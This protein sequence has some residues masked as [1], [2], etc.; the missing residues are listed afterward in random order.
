MIRKIADL[1]ADLHAS[2]WFIPMLMFSGSI[3]LAILLIQLDL[4]VDTEKLIEYSPIFAISSGGSRAMLAA[5]AGS[6]LTVVALAFTLTLNAMT[7][8]SGQFTPRILRNFMRDR[9]NQFILGYFVGVFAYS[10]LTLLAI[11]S[12]DDVQFVPILATFAGLFFTLGGVIVLIFFIHHIAASLQITTI[13]DKIVDD[14]KKSI[15]KLFPEDLADPAETDEQ[16]QAW[17]ADEDQQWLTVPTLSVGYIQSVDTNGLIKFA[18]E[19]N[20]IL[21]MECG[22]G[23]FVPR[24]A[25]LISLTNDRNTS[26]LDFKIG[27]EVVET[28]NGLFGIDRNRM[29]EQDVRFGIRQIVDIALKALSPGVNDTSTGVNCI[30]YLGDIIGELARKQFPLKVRS[31]DSEPRVIVAA[32]TFEDYVKTAFDQIRISGKGNVAIFEQLTQAIAYSASCTADQSRRQILKK[33]IDLIADFANQ[34]LDTKYEKEKF[35]I[36]LSKARS[37]FKQ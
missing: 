10:L 15:T 25:A 34:T 16:M 27:D 13:I 8:A 24:G 23:R 26:S 22:I 30:Q 36:K 33:Q 12:G 17:Q 9:A 18:E 21:R 14:T 28:L 20:L 19:N 31:N 7:H 37:A 1:W 32:P 5:V 35:R 11:R 29:I 4:A 3:V 2:L 6:M